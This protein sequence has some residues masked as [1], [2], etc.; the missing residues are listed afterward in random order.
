MDVLLLNLAN[1]VGENYVDKPYEPPQT[2]MP[3]L[4]LLYLAQVLVNSGYS[5]RVYDQCVTGLNNDELLKKI[6]QWDPKIIGFSMDMSNY[7]TTSALLKKVKAWN[8]NAIA[9]AGNYIP[10]FYYDKM[11]AIDDFD[12]C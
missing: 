1:M 12:Y 5:V 2:G 4:G 7:W 10:T 6:Q 11:M 9:V 3:P 8:P